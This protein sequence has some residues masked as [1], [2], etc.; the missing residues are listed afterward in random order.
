VK[1]IAFYNFKGGVGKTGLAVNLALD[2]EMALITNDVYSPLEEAIPKGRLL[3]IGHDEDFPVLPEDI[4]IVYD[5]GGYVDARARTVLKDSDFVLIPV[6][7]EF[8]SLQT[9]IHSIEEVKASN[10][11][12]IVIANKVKR[13][14]DFENIKKVITAVAGKF[15]LF[16]IKHTTA[17]DHVIE[18]GKSLRDF[19]EEGGSL[20]Y[21]F[22]AVLRQFDNIVSFMKGGK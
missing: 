2:E 6:E 8:R 20:G 14:G 3:K 5:L 7:N 12:I 9:T 18:Q 17:F 1:R 10:P 16:P 15:P 13:E 11:N 4:E 21:H 22:K 19:V